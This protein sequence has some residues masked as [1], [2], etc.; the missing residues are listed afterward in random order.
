MICGNVNYLS[1]STGVI[2]KSSCSL[3][4]HQKTTDCQTV[5]KLNMTLQKELP[6]FDLA[7][8]LTY[9]S[10]ACA[11][12]NNGE[13][14]SYWGLRISCMMPNNIPFATPAN[15]TEVKGF[16]RKHQHCSWKY[17]PRDLKQYHKSCVLHDTH[18]TSNQLPAMSLV[19]ELCYAYSMT[20]SVTVQL[21]SM[22]LTYRNPHCALCNLKGKSDR[23]RPQN[24]GSM[25]SPLSILLDVSS[26]ILN[27]EEQ[28]NSLTESI[29]AT[30]TQNLTSQLI[31]CSPN[32]CT[33]TFGGQICE[34]FTSLQN[35]S[36][37]RRS[38]INKSRVTR[39]R[40]KQNVF[41][42]NATDVQEN[43]VYIVCPK[44]QA[45]GADKD[46]KPR[47]T[48]LIYTTFVGTLL[49]II[50]L[51]F[52]LSLYLSFKELR[53]LPGKCLINLSLALLCFQ[54]I[55]LGVAKSSEVNSLC[56]AVAIFLHFFILAAFSWM[57]VMAF[58]T[59]NTFT[60]RGE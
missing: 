7:Q 44:N 45:G 50:S 21:P 57:S 40:Q 36:T 10:I 3:H 47:S 18:C 5:H 6:V 12:C 11:R 22:L 60:V 24:E 8:N 15:I 1:R 53:N 54:A 34:V 33:V 38:F 46:P 27:Q 17:S 32:N 23:L 41:E 42:N 26:N 58:D 9:R 43:N 59:A 13:N 19:K 25:T 52:L 30:A 35:L 55:F 49:S 39:M 2:M 31:N 28:E 14:L 37:Q 56:K 4:D 29:S 51:C 20:F 16:L 48:F